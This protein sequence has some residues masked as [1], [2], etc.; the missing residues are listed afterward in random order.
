MKHFWYSEKCELETGHLHKGNA[1]ALIDGE[2][3]EY[4]TCSDKKD[5]TFNWPDKIYLGMG[6]IYSINGVLQNAKL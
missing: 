1:I 4:S 3:K 5:I 2:F 6:A